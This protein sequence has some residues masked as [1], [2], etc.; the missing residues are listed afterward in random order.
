MGDNT[1]KN[2]GRLTLNPLKHMDM[3][4][5][6][7]LP[8][9]LL[10]AGSPIMFGYAKPV[11]YNPNN[12]SDRRYGPAKVALAGPGSNILLAVLLGLTLRFLPDVF[13]TPVAQQLLANIV[14]INLTLALFN[15]VPIPPLDGHWLLMTFLPVRFAGLRVFLYRY[16]MPLLFLFIF[17]GFGLLFPIIDFLFRLIVG[18]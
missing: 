12:L 4:G 5:S 3:F 18:V 15:L 16:S 6:V 13:I 1:A 2:M 10:L 11:P 8:L 7:M 9:F 14:A 17:F